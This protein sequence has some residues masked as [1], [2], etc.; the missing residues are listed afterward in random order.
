MYERS[1]WDPG[2]YQPHTC[3]TDGD[4]REQIDNAFLFNIILLFQVWFQPVQSTVKNA[5]T[6]LASPS[7]SA[8]C[9]MVHVASIVTRAAQ[10]NTGATVH[11]ARS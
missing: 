3:E 9:V 5:L 4:M 8:K 6:T 7:Q 11:N 10:V 1:T 2:K